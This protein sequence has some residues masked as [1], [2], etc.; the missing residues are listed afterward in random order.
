MLK[1]VVKEEEK[2]IEDDYKGSLQ[3]AMHGGKDALARLK[4]LRKERLEK[5]GTDPQPEESDSDAPSESDS[6]SEEVPEDGDKFQK[7]V[8]R[9]KKLTK[10]Q[11]N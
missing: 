1:Q 5:K 9:L 11:R 8:D 3:H 4:Q 6:D 7:P 2:Q 10:N